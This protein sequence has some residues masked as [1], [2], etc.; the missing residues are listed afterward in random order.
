MD[1]VTR[2]VDPG[3]QAVFAGV[4]DASKNPPKPKG[5]VGLVC[6]PYAMFARG[7]LS[8]VGRMLTA[9]AA[10]TLRDHGWAARGIALA[11]LAAKG[12]PPPSDVPVV[13]VSLGSCRLRTEEV[14]AFRRYR[15]AG[16]RLI[17]VGGEDAGD[18]TGLRD[19]M[20]RRS[21]DEVPVSSKWGVQNEKLWKGM[22]VSFAPAFGACGTGSFPLVRNPN[23]DGFCKPYAS[24]AFKPGAA[25]EPLAYLDNGRGR[26]LVA[27]RAGTVVW[28]PEYLLMPF[29][30]SR[31]TTLDWADMRL[32]SFGTNVLLEAMDALQTR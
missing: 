8:Y 5:T 28:L 30:F 22:S 20:E 21:D 31:D 11:A 17:A 18:A 14:E 9:S 1:A 6:E 13:F 3:L 7:R 12:L 4:F 19:L 15:A 32:D 16:G 24:F 2:T 27:A 25:V 29:L 10:R 26:L 23:I